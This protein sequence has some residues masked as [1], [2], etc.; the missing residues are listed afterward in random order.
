MSKKSVMIKSEFTATCLIGLLLAVFLQFACRAT[1]SVAGER[2]ELADVFFDDFAYRT[3]DEFHQNNWKVRTRAGHPGVEGA[4][5]SAEGVS[6]HS[7]VRGAANGI[8]RLTAATDGTGAN[9]RHAQF[10]HARKYL[11]GTYAARVYFRDQPTFGPDG[12]QVIQTF[13]AISPLTAPMHPD[14]SEVDFEYLPNGGWGTGDKPA[15]WSTTWE[16]FQLEPW[17]RDNEYTRKQGSYAGWHTLVLTVANEG[18]AYYVDGVLL[19]SHSARVAP[20]A[21]MSINFNLWFTPQ[22]VDGANAPVQ[23]HKMRQYQQ[24]VDW[25]FHRANAVMAHSEVEQTVSALRS[26]NLLYID[27]VKPSEP[28]LESLCTL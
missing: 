11:Q 2:A 26:Q 5:W 8:V 3:F 13:Y 16:T 21:P 22:S 4:R 23:S 19:S 12:D 25:V 28:P 10:C 17:A 9:T 27:R 20:E 7:N 15:I 1:V 14:F 24:D 6:L 18:V